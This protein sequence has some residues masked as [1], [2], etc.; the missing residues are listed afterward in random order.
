[1]LVRRVA[2][3]NQSLE[4]TG[5]AALLPRGAWSPRRG[6]H[7]NSGVRLPKREQCRLL[8]FYVDTEQRPGR[9]ARGG[10]WRTLLEVLATH[11]QKSVTSQPE[12]EVIRVSLV[13]CPACGRQISTDA[14][15]CPQCGHPNRATT[16]IQVGPNCYA[17][18]AAATTRCQGCGVLSCPQHLQS[19]SVLRGYV[20]ANEL[21]CDSCSSSAKSTTEGWQMY[22]CILGAFFGIIAFL[23]ILAQM[24]GR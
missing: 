24:R 21:L 8:C 18:S 4:V 17:C 10:I 2:G 23:I 1:L 11:S 22:F 13:S 5:R 14:E 20:R 9:A 7:L 19:I 3:T 15:A 12:Q 6:Q 16:R